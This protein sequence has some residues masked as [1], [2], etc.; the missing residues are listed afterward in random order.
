MELDIIAKR[1]GKLPSEI[2]ELDLYDYQFNL[3]V[4]EKAIQ[5]ENRLVEK[6]SRSRPR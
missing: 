3:L 5:E 1:Y 4:I 6:T 2:I